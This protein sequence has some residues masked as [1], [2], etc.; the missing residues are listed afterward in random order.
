MYNIFMNL[1]LQADVEEKCPD[2]L[3]LGLLQGDMSSEKAQTGLTEQ[4]EWLEFPHK[5]FMDYIVAMYISS[6]GVV[7]LTS[8]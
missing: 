6:L 5:M 1:S 3:K 7:S 4:T 2:A 8:C